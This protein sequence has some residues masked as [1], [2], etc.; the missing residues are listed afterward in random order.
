[1]MKGCRTKNVY[2]VKEGVL[3]VY[4][5]DRISAKHY[6]IPQRATAAGIVPLHAMPRMRHVYGPGNVKEKILLLRL[7]GNLCRSVYQRSGA[8]RCGRLTFFVKSGYLIEDGKLTQPIKDINIIGNG[9]KHWR[10][11]HGG[12]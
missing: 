7:E 8:D 3:T 2:I 4:L 1:M 9:P 5:H 12:G 10:Y 11:H 6:G